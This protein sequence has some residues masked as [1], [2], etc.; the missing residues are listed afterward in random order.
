MSRSESY[1]PPSD[2][3]LAQWRELIE[4]TNRCDVERE[5]LLRAALKK[6]KKVDLVNFTDHRR[7]ATTDFRL[8]CW[9]LTR[10]DPSRESRVRDLS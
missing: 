1:I 2:E 7:G 8:R 10:S 4:A 5:K 3:E 9:P 6:M